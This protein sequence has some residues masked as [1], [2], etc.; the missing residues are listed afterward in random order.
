MAM[1]RIARI[2][3]FSDPHFSVDSRIEEESWF[4]PICNL[5]QKID[6]RL[7]LE[8]SLVEKF[9][10]FWDRI[11]QKNMRLFLK[12]A[13]LLGPYDYIFGLGDYTPGT[14]ESG[15]V[16]EKSIGQFKTFLRL[17]KDYFW[18]SPL[19]LTWGDHDVGYRFNVSKKTGVKIGSETG[20][21]SLKSVLVADKLLN[22]AWGSLKIGKA[23]V[24][25]LSTN[26]IRASDD[27]DELLRRMSDL[28]RK[29]VVYSLMEADDSDPIFLFLHDPTALHPDSVIM[30]AMRYIS[31]KKKIIIIHGHMHAEYS[32]FL[33][34][35][36]YKPYRKL[37]K[38]FETILVPAP[39][40]MF[41][42]GKGFKVL[43]LFDDGSYQIEKHRI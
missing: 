29:A 32:A 39:W 43:N 19:F 14:N 9:L 10:K 3:L 33:T 17:L 15:M 5:L 25:A 38:K 42:I 21:I 11:T 35:L 6:R 28:Q 36:F 12:K 22:K 7:H 18:D 24:I 16:T 26:L 41:G 8:A 4:P 1:N 30:D 34:R 27:K 20:G 37:C 2:L 13:S 40:G 31:K 23:K